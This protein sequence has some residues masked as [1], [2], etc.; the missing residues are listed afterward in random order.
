LDI[1]SPKTIS[2]KAELG[3]RATPLFKQLCEKL[4]LLER[5]T[6]SAGLRFS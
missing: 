3:P 5:V 6:V 4:G 2:D 1:E